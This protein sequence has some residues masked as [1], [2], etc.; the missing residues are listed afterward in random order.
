MKKKL[1]PIIFAILLWGCAGMLHAQKA[2]NKNVVKDNMRENRFHWEEFAQKTRSG[3]INEE[4]GVYVL[5]N[6]TKFPLN[7]FAK[8]VTN[9]PLDPKRN[10]KYKVT[11][12]VP[13]ISKNYYLGLVWGYRNQTKEVQE[14]ML[15]LSNPNADRLESSYGFSAFMVSEGKYKICGG[16]ENTFNYK[17]LPF[18]AGLTNVLAGSVLLRSGKD[19]E[20]VLEME[21]KGKNLIFSVNNMEVATLEE[22]I[23]SRSFGF[24]VEG[25]NTIKVKE[26]SIEQIR[27]DDDM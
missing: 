13:K 16:F 8:S 18:F 4:E 15:R 27:V 7:P 23:L 1:K 26:V 19:K 20:V 17:P 6:R 14:I 10:F 3:F 2:N 9:L 5:R 22:E 21:K 24:I 25:K 11:L 12:I